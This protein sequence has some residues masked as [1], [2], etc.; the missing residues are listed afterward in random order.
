MVAGTAGVV[1]ALLNS[2]K[3][4]THSL[5]SLTEDDLQ[6]RVKEADKLYKKAVIKGS[7]ALASTILVV[8]IVTYSNTK[9]ETP[10]L[11]GAFSVGSSYGMIQTLKSYYA[12]Y[13]SLQG[14]R[15]L[16]QK[17]SS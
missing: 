17:Q 5:E 10:I 12:L 1:A 2:Q 9:Y 11:I 15:I 4:I 3:K 13:T 6:S 16:Q 8:G 14:S 7:L